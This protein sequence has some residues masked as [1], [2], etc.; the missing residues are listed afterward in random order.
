MENVLGLQLFAADP[1]LICQSW[2]SCPSDVSCESRTSG[3]PVEGGG[4]LW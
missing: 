3:I 1:F 2:V 4:N